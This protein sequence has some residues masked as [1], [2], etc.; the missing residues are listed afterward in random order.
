MLKNIAEYDIDLSLIEIERM[1]EMAFKNL[2]K[3]KEASYSL[4]YPNELKG[5]HTKVMDI[6]VLKMADYFTPNEITNSQAKF[7]FNARTRMLDVKS[8]KENIQ[9][10]CVHCAMRRGMIRNICSCAKNWLWR[11]QW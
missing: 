5:R 1:S 10:Q 11:E 7:L 6:S 8:F 4:R 2:V 9:I 3:E